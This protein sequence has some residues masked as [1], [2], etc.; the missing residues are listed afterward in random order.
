L[1]DITARLSTA[2]AGRYKLTRLVGEGGMACPAV[3]SFETGTAVLRSPAQQGVSKGGE[4]LR[5]TAGR[6]A[7]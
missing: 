7:L 5:N 3:R 2:L 6:R 4:L 1:P